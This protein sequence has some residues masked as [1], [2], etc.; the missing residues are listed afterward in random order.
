MRETVDSFSV[1]NRTILGHWFIEGSGV[2]ELET[3]SR[4][5]CSGLFHSRDSERLGAPVS[6]LGGPPEVT[7]VSFRRPQSGTGKKSRCGDRTNPWKVR[8]M[9]ANVGGASF[10]PAAETDPVQWTKMLELNL[11]ASFYCA[12]ATRRLLVE[13]EIGSVVFVGAVAAFNPTP[14]FAGYGA[15]KAG[16]EHLVGSLASE[17]GPDIRVNAVSPGLILTEG[18]L[19]AVFGGSQDLAD[20]PGK[21]TTA[22]G[23]LGQPSDIGMACQYLLSPASAFVSGTV[24]KI[25]GGAV[26]GPTQRILSAV[27][28]LK[29]R[30]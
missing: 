13:S 10:G 17:W 22:V 15:A 1:E 12:Q 25:D 7:V 4:T 24:L 3:P 26:E 19:A 6:D 27:N 9:V 29:D 2:L 23:R 16:V 8:W 11:S 28:A 18:S 5:R 30:P 20:R 14:M 21:V